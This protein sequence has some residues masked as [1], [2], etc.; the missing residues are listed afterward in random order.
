MIYCL[1]CGGLE[2]GDGRDGLQGE[3]RL[4]QASIDVITRQG[5]LSGPFASITEGFLA[6]AAEGQRRPLRIPVAFPY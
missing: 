2:R 6:G 4:T 5:G 3:I 1:P